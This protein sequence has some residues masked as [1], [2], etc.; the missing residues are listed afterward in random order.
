MK[1]LKTPLIV[2]GL[3]SA[4][5]LYFGMLDRFVND[6]GCPNYFNSPITVLFPA[7]E[8]GVWLVTD[9]ELTCEEEDEK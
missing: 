9:F 1:H 4:G 7:L 5:F 2:Y 3:A 6:E 8:L